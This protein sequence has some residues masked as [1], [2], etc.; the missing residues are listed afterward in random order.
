MPL[1]GKAAEVAANSDRKAAAK[2]GSSLKLEAR[3]PGRRSSRGRW[4]A[5]ATVIRPYFMHPPASRCRGG[6][7]C[8]PLR[9]LARVM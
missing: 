1:L 2:A 6:G 3:S 5:F 7:A 4:I 9:G 8:Y